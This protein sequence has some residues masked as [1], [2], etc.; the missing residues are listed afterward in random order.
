MQSL[1]LC[2]YRQPVEGSRFRWGVLRETRDTKKEPLSWAT[3]T[4]QYRKCD[5]D[6][7]RSRNID[8]VQTSDGFRC[9]YRERQTWRLRI[10]FLGSLVK[11][12]LAKK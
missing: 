7:E 4:G 11:P 1:I 2:S 8:T 5:P 12:F 3:I 6:F 9:M 10:P